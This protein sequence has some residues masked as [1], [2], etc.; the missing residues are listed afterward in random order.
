M[1]EKW[2]QGST[3]SKPPNK[4]ELAKPRYRWA[5]GWLIWVKFGHHMRFSILENAKWFD[6]LA[7]AFISFEK[8]KHE[9]G[10]CR[11]SY[12]MRLML[13][14]DV[15]KDEKGICKG[16]IFTWWRMPCFWLKSHRQ[17]ACSTWNTHSS[18]VA[19]GQATLRAF[20]SLVLSSVMKQTGPDAPLPPKA[21]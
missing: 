5:P 3:H 7:Q 2:Q 10:Q 18:W 12:R 13:K 21:P 16:Y 8:K 14:M 6:F 19:L 4:S 20:R 9:E 11:T 15:Y 17:V 1:G